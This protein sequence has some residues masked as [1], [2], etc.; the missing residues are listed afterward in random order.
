MQHPTNQ[1][2]EIVMR[3]LALR[4]RRPQRPGFLQRIPWIASLPDNHPRIAAMV[5]YW[6][7]ATALSAVV[8]FIQAVPTLVTAI[9]QGAFLQVLE[10]LGWLL[11]YSV[12]FGPVF[13]PVWLLQ[14]I[15]G[16]LGPLGGLALVALMFVAGWK[17]FGWWVHLPTRAVH[18]Q[19]ARHARAQG[20]VSDTEIVKTFG[21]PA[22]TKIGDIEVTTGAIPLGYVLD[23]PI[24]IPWAADAGHMAVVGPT[25]SGK[26]LHLTD[27]L[28]RWPGPVVCIDPKGEQWQRTAAFRQQA[29]G[30]VFRIP[31]QG[32][33]LGELYNLDHD[34]D[35][36]ELH[37]MLLRPWQ[38]GNDRIFADKAL[39]LFTAAVKY[40][41]ATGEHPLAV[42]GRWAQDSPVHA[43]QQASALAPTPIQVF[44]DGVDPERISQNRFALSSWGNFSTRFSP[45]SAHVS[46]ITQTTVPRTWA[47]DNASIYITYPL[48]SQNAVGPLAA[49]LIGGLV[50]QLLANPPCKRVLF[51]IDEMPTV[52]LPNLTGYLATV[53]GAGMT[54]VLYAQ[55]LPQIEDVYGREAA[56][57]ILSNCTSQ[58]FF[59]PREPHTAELISRSFGSRLEVTQQ[60][61]F[62]SVSYGS[63]YQPEMEAAEV[64][65]L[66]E[67]SLIVFSQGLRHIAQ[68]SRKAVLTWLP[69]MPAAPEVEAPKVPE[70]DLAGVGS[71]EKE[72]S[73]TFW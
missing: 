68:D 64:M 24:G 29:Y 34:L 44:T 26:G 17:I 25:R 27:T 22:P 42:L 63:R 31:P 3:V 21:L 54:M 32:L 40:G 11:V 53:G 52:G 73:Q 61:T 70:P 1:L 7:A 67:G 35:V 2:I 39:S 62:D 43:L 69:L 59:P 47:Q 6:F 50:R 19:A 45:F 8:V 51:A 71:K 23:K 72:E 30:P 18:N 41:H 12:A 48:Q 37:E 4:H 57:S 20:R 46:T 14:L 49:A 38:D 58:L 15:L 36:R 9:L 10:A 65:S 56:L 33:D 60:A 13:A 5:L 55:A 66:K 28:I 16:L